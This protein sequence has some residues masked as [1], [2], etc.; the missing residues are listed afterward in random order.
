MKPTQNVMLV[1]VVKQD[2][3]HSK[4]FRAAVKGTKWSKGLLLPIY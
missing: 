4:S 2:K 3:K 1:L